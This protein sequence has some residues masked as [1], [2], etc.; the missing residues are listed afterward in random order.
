[1]TLLRKIGDLYVSQPGGREE[2]QQIL[3]LVFDVQTQSSKGVLEPVFELP[4]F[5]RMWTV[6]E[7]TLPD[8]EN[9]VVKYGPVSFPW[10]C[11]LRAMQLLEITK[12]KWGNWNQATLLQRSIA[13]MLIKNDDP[14]WAGHFGV[15]SS[16][17]LSHGSS[18]TGLLAAMR[19]KK[20]TDP[21]DKAFALYAVAHKLGLA[22][23]LPNY[24]K[25][26]EQTYSDTAVACIEQDKTLDV[27]YEAP[28]DKRDPGL[29]SWVPD[30]S[31]EQSTSANRLEYIN[32][33][34]QAG[35]GCGARWSFSTDLRL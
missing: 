8:L 20:A 26:L 6:Q 32:K 18:L 2:R 10:W 7:A 9:M 30:W 11:L 13:T 19:P 12:F 21:R 29:P 15:E 33:G 25:S 5:F 16:N 14:G 23:P 3:E 1:M 27:L 24:K 34:F 28:S 22:L 31:D 35:G 17:T 4:W